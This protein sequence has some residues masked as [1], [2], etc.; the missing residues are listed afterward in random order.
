MEEHAGCKENIVADAFFEGIRPSNGSPM[1]AI[2]T[3][4]LP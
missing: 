4:W 2:I 3:E 1:N